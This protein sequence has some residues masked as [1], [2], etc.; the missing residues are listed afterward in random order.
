[1]NLVGKDLTAYSLETVE[2]FHRDAQAAAFRI[3]T[4]LVAA[5]K[6]EGQ[7]YSVRADVQ[8]DFRGLGEV[9]REVVGAGIGS[10]ESGTD[11]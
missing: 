8:D 3:D 6:A 7:R 1:M 9:P 4:S 5:A 10:V 2:M 11:A